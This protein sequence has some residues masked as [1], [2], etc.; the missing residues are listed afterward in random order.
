MGNFASKNTQLDVT[1]GAAHAYEQGLIAGERN[2]DSATAGYQVTV[3]ETT[4]TVVDVSTNS[5]SVSG[6]APALLLG[7]YVNTAIATEAVGLHDGTGGTEVITLPIAA[8]A[9]SYLEFPGGKFTTSIYV[10]NTNATG[11]ITVFWRAV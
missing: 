5:V 1:S 8:A 3:P 11:S 7:I 10:E 6:D 2:P 9:G 4:A